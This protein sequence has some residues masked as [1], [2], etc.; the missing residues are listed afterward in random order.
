MEKRKSKIK[1]YIILLVLILAAYGAAFIA[2][3]IKARKDAKEDIPQGEPEIHSDNDIK[4]DDDKNSGDETHEPT[5][6]NI[7]E[8]IS[9]F[10]MQYLGYAYTYGGSSPDTG[11]DCSGF[12]YYVLN[13]TGHKTSARS[14][15]ELY[16]ASTKITKDELL[17]G[18][19]V[20]FTGTYGNAEVSHVGMYIGEDRMIHSGDETTGVCIAN[21]WEDY[22]TS[23]FYSY[24]RI[25]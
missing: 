20:F 23:H 22:W 9:E 4:S 8:E 1:Y 14:S 21:L 19:L 13:H 18:D 16:R 7:G 10:A 2:N 24:G 11:F 12:V 17:P 25:R 15:L 3:T 5:E 6:A